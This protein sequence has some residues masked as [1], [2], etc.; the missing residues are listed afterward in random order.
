MLA[1]EEADMNTARALRTVAAVLGSMGLLLCFTKAL[2]FDSA[3][4]EL[5]T[6]DTYNQPSPAPPRPIGDG[7]FGTPPA[8]PSLSGPQEDMLTRVSDTTRAGHPGRFGSFKFSRL[9]VMRNSTIVNDWNST[10]MYLTAFARH[11]WG[12]DRAISGLYS[13]SASALTSVGLDLTQCRL[14]TTDEVLAPD[15]TG[16]S[17]GWVRTRRLWRNPPPADFVAMG[18]G[19]EHMLIVQAAAKYAGLDQNP[20]FTDVF[21]VRYP[22]SDGYVASPYGK[23]SDGRYIVGQSWIPARMGDA[24]AHVERGIYL[25]ELAQMPDV[26]NSVWDWL[27]G[28]ELCPDSILTALHQ[29]NA[30]IFGGDP[31][32]EI[33]ACHAFRRVMGAL[34][35]SHFLPAARDF[36]AYYH[37][38]ALQRMQVCT[39]LKPI[40]DAFARP[41]VT[42]SFDIA[43]WE[44]P[45]ALD[46]EAHECEREAFVYEMFAQHY[47]QDAWSTG[48]M[49]HRWGSP[50]LSAF[51]DR[52]GAWPYGYPSPGLDD[53]QPAAANLAARRYLIAAMTAAF[54]GMIHGAKGVTSDLYNQ[55]QKVFWFLNWTPA[56]LDDPLSGPRY[57]SPWD[58][59]SHSVS[60][61]RGPGTYPGAGDLFWNYTSSDGTQ[62]SIAQQAKYDALRVNLL[63]CSAK[64]LRDVYGTGPAMHG[65]MGTAITVSPIAGIT[66]PLDPNS[67][68]VM[69]DC[70]QQRVT[71]DS[72][73][74]SIGPFYMHRKW[75]AAGAN[76]SDAIV[77]II[78]RLANIF[79][80]RSVASGIVFADDK[81]GAQ[82]SN[83]LAARIQA[84]MDD[85]TLQFS[86][87]AEKRGQETQAAQLIRPG[88]TPL[89]P[90]GFLGVA[91]NAPAP[92]PIPATFSDTFAPVRSAPAQDDGTVATYAA[93][94][95]WRSHLAESCQDADA[96]PVLRDRCVNA[97]AGGGDPDACTA[98]VSLAELWVKPCGFDAVLGQSKCEM[99][100]QT[101]HST[102]LPAFWFDKAACTCQPALGTLDPHSDPNCGWSTYRLATE[103]CTGTTAYSG[104]LGVMPVSLDT[105]SSPP[106]DV[107]RISVFDDFDAL[108][109]PPGLDSSP[110]RLR[111][112]IS[113]YHETITWNSVPATNAVGQSFANTN[114]VADRDA[115]LAQMLSPLPLYNDA[116]QGYRALVGRWEYASVPMCGQTQRYSFW[117][118]GCGY[119]L[120][121][122]VLN[123][124]AGLADGSIDLPTGAFF[125]THT[126]PS[127]IEP[128]Q[129]PLGGTPDASTIDASD[130]AG[131][132]SSAGAADATDGSATSATAEIN[133][134]PAPRCSVREARTFT[135]ACAGAAMCG[136]GGAC[137]FARAASNGALVT[138]LAPP[139]QVLH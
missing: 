121:S 17:P 93:R 81:D 56:A 99:V 116:S 58:D 4:A 89:G 26:S 21:W 120:G 22:V 107:Y 67:V 39:Q 98:C 113:A 114:A 118:K 6:P 79:A 108:T 96:V 78:L 139:V 129:P 133:G 5:K 83:A 1:P 38:L 11:T 37:G 134:P 64:S 136:S 27:A 16:N 46:T 48:H 63:A 91:P 51:P 31:A 34:N 92:S 40:A 7:F 15:D 30:A 100:G 90:I 49:W 119:V 36:Y 13:C 71:N 123:V 19:A 137:V 24:T 55:A 43:N 29:N 128:E 23:S 57:Y 111:P 54:A 104:G 112:M 12:S 97:A 80:R 69:T 84:D 68:N 70:F 50:D 126:G 8:S 131:A 124:P 86:I 76:Y 106:I 35:S 61:A 88:T 10:P 74:G 45:I 72:M 109:F 2:A 65:A 52:L 75:D 60:W 125:M 32:A 28:D 130:A 73:F 102:K 132:D 14:P 62:I 103:Y 33:N 18:H 53:T 138:P 47:L 66:A 44:D 25:P 3:G 122:Y 42:S 85:V 94:V 135:P 117:N 105:T 95:F 77:P 9:D 41:P 115:V 101:A 110:H 59:Q 127:I 20:L 87:H 82:F